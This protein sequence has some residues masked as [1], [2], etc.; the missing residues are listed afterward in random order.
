MKGVKTTWGVIFGEDVRV[1]MV[2]TFMRGGS[3]CVIKIYI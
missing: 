3:D 2:E 1:E